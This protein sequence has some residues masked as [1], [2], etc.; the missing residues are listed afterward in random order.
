MLGLILVSG[1]ITI[2]AL[3]AA[4]ANCLGEPSIGLTWSNDQQPG[5]TGSDAYS[6]LGGSDWIKGY[7]GALSG[8]TDVGDFLC[9]DEDLDRLYGGPG[10]D[11][12][13]GGTG[14]DGLKGDSFPDVLWGKAGADTLWGNGGDDEIHAGDGDDNIAE[15]GS[16]CEQW[17][18]CNG[19]DDIFGGAG[20]DRIN[21]G[22]E[23]DEISDV[24]GNDHDVICDGDGFDDVDVDDGDGDDV[25]FYSTVDGNGDEN[26]FKT[27]PGDR[28]QAGGC[29]VNNIDTLPLF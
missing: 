29:S 6:G 1:Y 10:R 23:N 25:I 8:T 28:L 27:D 24:E 15:G 7:P 26:W 2:S 9:G 14:N 11:E 13:D 21:A 19:A 5:H 16:T 18:P 3:P 12:L 17:S 20:D 22:P 4:A